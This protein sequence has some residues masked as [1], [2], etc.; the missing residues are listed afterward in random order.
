MLSLLCL[1]ALFMLLRQGLALQRVARAQA[2]TLEATVALR[3]SELRELTHHLQTAREDERNR[4]AR[5][6]HDE[7][8]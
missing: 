5:D 4:L 6:L 8:G 2:D 7:L 3:T 1:L